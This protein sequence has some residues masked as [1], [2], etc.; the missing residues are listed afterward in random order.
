MN[1]YCLHLIAWIDLPFFFLSTGL[2]NQQELVP[3]LSQGLGSPQ[4][5]YQQM[6]VLYPS[7][8]SFTYLCNTLTFALELEETVT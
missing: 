5:E 8:F 4:P 7:I 3:L 6:V 1:C 2:P